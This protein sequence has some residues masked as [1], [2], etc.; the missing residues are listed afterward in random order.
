MPLLHTCSAAVD[1]R[2]AAVIRCVVAERACIFQKKM[3]AFRFC[4]APG[5]Y[6]QQE[7]PSV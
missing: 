1:D 4:P 3:T 7:Y 5:H 6:V 2:E